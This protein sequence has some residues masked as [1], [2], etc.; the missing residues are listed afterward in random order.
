LRRR[1]TSPARCD[2]QLRDHVELFRC[3]YNFLRPHR[4]LRFAHE[5]RTPAMQAGLVSKPLTWSHIFKAGGP[6]P[7]LF[8]AVRISVY[9]RPT[10]F[11]AADPPR[12]FGPR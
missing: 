12:I 10:E 6:S 8:E 9:V 7:C 11:A 1:S 4:A 5:I 3:H 2:D